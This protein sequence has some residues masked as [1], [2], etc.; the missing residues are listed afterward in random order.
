MDGLTFEEL[1]A[2]LEALRENNKWIILAGHEVGENSRYSV[3]AR[4]L[5]QLIQYLNTPEN[6]YWVDTVEK[7]A[8]YIKMHRKQPG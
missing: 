8:S 1:K 6:G 4:V 3:D 5:S 2:T 7:V